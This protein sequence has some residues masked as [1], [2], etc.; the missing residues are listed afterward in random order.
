M[1][2]LEKI[3]TARCLTF[4]ALVAGGQSAALVLLLHGNEL[5]LQDIANH[6]L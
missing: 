2:R 5:L 1:T 3:T 6:P 4:D